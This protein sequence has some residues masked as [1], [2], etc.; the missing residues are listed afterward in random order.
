MDEAAPRFAEEMRAYEERKADLLKLCEGKY[1]VFKGSEYLGVFDDPIAAYRAALSK[2]GNV[3]FMIR[4]VLSQEPVHH[5]PSL[6]LGL[7]HVHL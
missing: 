3:L 5:F 1:A 6:H 2:W 4:Q 7:H